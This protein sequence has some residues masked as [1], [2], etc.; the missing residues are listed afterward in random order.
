[1]AQPHATN[2]KVRAP[3]ML[4]ALLIIVAL[5]IIDTFVTDIIYLMTWLIPVVFFTTVIALI[6]MERRIRRRKPN[7]GHS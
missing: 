5:A 1:M 3:F 4:P 7:L 6:L 2:L